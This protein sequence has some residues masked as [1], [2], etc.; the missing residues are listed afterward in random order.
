MSTELFRTAMKE[1][2][3]LYDGPIHADGVLRRFKAEGDDAPNSWYVLHA[4]TV[5]AGAFGCWKR[6]FTEN[7]CSAFLDKLS[8]ADRQAVANR[9]AR[10][11]AKAE[12]QRRL[13]IKEGTTKAGVAISEASPCGGHPYLGGK[14]VTP[15]PGLRLDGDT[16]LVPLV[17]RGGV[18]QSVQRIQ[19]DGKKRF[20]RGTSPSGA[21]FRIPGKLGGPIVV[22]EG[23]ATGSSVHEATGFEAWCAMSCANLKSIVSQIRELH[24][25]RKVIIAGDDDTETAGNPGRT[26]AEAVAAELRASVVFP[27]FTT[28]SGTDWND[29]HCAEGIEAVRAQLA[30]LPA[31]R[32]E[33]PDEAV[34]R[35][36]KLSPFEYSIHRREASKAIRCSVGAL[37]DEVRRAR[38]EAGGSV[39]TE[40]SQVWPDPVD[41]VELL[42]TIAATFRR[43]LVLPEK[44]PEI[45]ATW[46]LHTHCFERFEFTPYLSI[47]SPVMR[48]GKSTLLDLL[49]RITNSPEMA[50]SVTAA[51][52]FR[53]VEEEKPTL[54]I[55]EWDGLS[56]ETREG[57]RSIL[58]S[59]FKFDGMAPRCDG[60]ENKVRKFKTFSPKAIAGIGKLPHTIADRSIPIV[61]QRKGAG[62]RVERFRK[63]CG[64][65]IRAKCRRWV[66]DNAEGLEDIGVLLPGGLSDRQQD[67]LECLLQIA[68]AAGGH[69]PEAVGNAIAL[70]F[71]GSTENE[72][73][74]DQL[75]SDIKGLFDRYDLDRLSSADICAKLTDMEDRPWP[76]YKAGRPIT[77]PQLA[78]ALSRFKIIP[79]TIRLP[80]GGT[81]RGYYKAAFEDVFERY[82]PPD[83]PS[84]RHTD[85]DPA[86]IGDSSLLDP[87]QAL[88]C[89][90]TENTVSTN[91]T[92]GCV[93]VSV[94]KGVSALKL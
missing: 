56:V 92:S 87:T 45:L 70:T 80:D 19:P 35:L 57:M 59:G 79:G 64:K 68:T 34:R 73:Q 93:G 94:Q 90:G 20:M 55:D 58:N 85:T 89:V 23:L 9:H 51:V 33:T 26:S 13:E 31:P 63:Y 22:V 40:D 24:P 8:P 47:T 54:L 74:A 62:D 10:A 66:A 25:D 2:G 69:W 72:S 65:E 28:G 12:E 21:S 41:G 50:S 44:A 43:F 77:Q 48:C 14:R 5:P 88:G 78:R 42:D 30:V 75:L 36:A 91:G 7:W 39:A 29:L 11:K 17:D 38:V 60:P 27:K 81:A 67:I 15:A 18:V 53:L 46:V 1:K 3:L 83:P 32:A 52:I 4:D 61:L 76:E 84:R 82:L 37:D 16:L 6:Q 71:N 86:N 49:N